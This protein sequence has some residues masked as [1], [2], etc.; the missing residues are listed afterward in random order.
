MIHTT[1]EFWGPP[2]VA[3][4]SLAINMTYLH[5]AKMCVVPFIALAEL[6]GQRYGDSCRGRGS[7]VQRDDCQPDLQRELPS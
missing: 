6:T 4:V 5:P 2:L 3:G 1:S 7:E